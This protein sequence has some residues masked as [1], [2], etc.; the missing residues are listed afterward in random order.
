MK[1]IIIV[2]L[3]LL[4]VSCSTIKSR[5]PFLKEEIVTNKI[6]ITDSTGDIF[7]IEPFSEIYRKKNFD[8]KG[9]EI[10][11]EEE[12]YIFSIKVD[13]RFENR[14]GNING[15]DN[16]IIDI[17]FNMGIGKYHQT[18]KN[19]NI[20]I[21]EGWDKVLT[22]HPNLNEE[23]L[24]ND[25]IVV[26]DKSKIEN[27]RGNFIF[28]EDITVSKDTIFFK[29]KKKDFNIDK[30]KSLQVFTL[31]YDVITDENPE[32]IMEIDKKETL[33]NFGGGSN[34]SGDTNVLDILGENKQLKEYLSEEEFKEYSRIEMISI[35]R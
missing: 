13:G 21:K 17:Y 5:L 22:L 24:K 6:N 11:E 27:L 8:I 35:K 1:K 31:S 7:F 15:W 34:F 25:I 2:L 3:A 9:F 29:I 18:L 32:G 20:V 19:R 30:I 12:E 16:Q 4:S 14:K 23:Y 33:F 26:D 10:V 28:P